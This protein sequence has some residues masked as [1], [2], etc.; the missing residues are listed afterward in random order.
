MEHASFLSAFTDSIDEG[1]IYVDETEKIQLYNK[2]A[3]EIFGIVE[4]SGR[5]H[6]TGRVEEGDLIL[7]ADHRLFG[8][9]GMTDATLF[10]EYGLPIDRLSRGDSIVAICRHGSREP[11]AFAHKG[12]RENRDRL[13]ISTELGGIHL[14]CTLD[15]TNKQARLCVGEIAFTMPYIRSVGHM[16]VLGGTTLTVKFYQAKGYTVRRETLADLIDGHPFVAKGKNQEIEVVGRHPLEI[17]DDSEIIRRFVALAGGRKG[18]EQTIRNGYYEI[19]GRPALCTLK[20]IA[21]NGAHRGAL[22]IVEDLTELEALIAEK[23]SALDKLADLE[24]QLSGS[25]LNE[26]PLGELVGDSESIRLVRDLAHR[27]SLTT[28]TVMI[29]GESGTGK[30]LLASLIHRTSGRA[31]APFVQVN[32]ASI[33]ENLIESELF[34]YE[35]GAFTGATSGGKRGFFE[36]AD[37][38]TLFLD[39]IGELPLGL[40]A[41]LLGVLQN[42]SFFRVGGTKAVTVDVRIIAASNRDLA[43]QVT[44]GLFREDLYYRIS[45]FPILIPP[46][47]SRFRDVGQ[48]ARHLLPK[49]TKKLGVSTKQYSQEALEKLSHHH[50]PGNIRELENAIE[51]AINLTTGTVIDADAIQLMTPSKVA[52][53]KPL[54]E[55]LEETEREAI[56]RALKLSG[57]DRQETMRRLGIKKSAYY[58]K[59]ARYQIENV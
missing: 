41:K 58:D 6:P 31:A 42:R 12:E 3:K 15:F 47:R 32:C 10:A 55:L 4:D 35:G 57:G 46:L 59:I 48:V 7:L 37:G 53:F 17:H 11:I 23:N 34:G 19:N 20:R 39:E 36:E 5:G 33:P 54:K 2:R 26:G 44:K 16:V 28:S 18:E 13:E 40:Q 1:L 24:R 45:V 8:D 14:S 27:A 22:L 52:Q 25:D 30:T 51:R 21:E 50:W 29:E 49:L 43:A 38:G 9:D 56:V